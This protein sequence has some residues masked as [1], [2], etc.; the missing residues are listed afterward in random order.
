MVQGSVA[1]DLVATLPLAKELVP[2]MAWEKHNS[3]RRVACPG[4]G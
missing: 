1:R 2:P 3:F 4:M